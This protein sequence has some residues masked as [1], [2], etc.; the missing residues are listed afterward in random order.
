MTKVLVRPAELAD[1][2]SV[3]EVHV[4]SWLKAYRGLVPDSLLD[5]LTV[6]KREAFW[7]QALEQGSVELW[8]AESVPELVVGWVAF[9]ASRDTD[10]PPLTGEIEAIYIHPDHF[11]RGIGRELW[12]VARRRLVE[13]GF[14]RA[15]LWVFE[16]NHP[17]LHFYRTLGLSPDDGASKVIERD[18]K[19]LVEVRYEAALR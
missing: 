2:R 15:T 9:G 5:R 3:A 14:E 4:A 7:R 19:K 16:E 8:V 18:G 11:R 6:E 10:A 1:A 12:D 17:A 13:R